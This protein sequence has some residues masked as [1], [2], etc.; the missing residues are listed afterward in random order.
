M[1]LSLHKDTKPSKIL[2]VLR[3]SARALARFLRVLHLVCAAGTILVVQ[4]LLLDVSHDRLGDQVA[5]A[6]VAF[7]EQADFCAR[8][9]VLHQLLYNVDVVFPLL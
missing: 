4:S 1:L 5:D 2:H 8:N 3:G 9:V 6:H 7:A